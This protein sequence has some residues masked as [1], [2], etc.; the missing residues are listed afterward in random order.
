MAVGAYVLGARVLEQHFTLNHTWKGTDHA[1]SLE[2]IGMRKLVRDLRRIR[3]ALGDGEKSV[4]PNEVDPIVKMSK[5]LVAAR[6]LP[7][8]HRLTHSDI[9]IKSPGD[10]L[11]P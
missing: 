5:K 7:A 6:D 9:A 3:V 1:F 4:K 2:P 8:G 11:P 10:G